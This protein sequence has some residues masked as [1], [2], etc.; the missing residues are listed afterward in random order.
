[1]ALVFLTGCKKEAEDKLRNAFHSGT[2]RYKMTVTVETPEGEKTGSAVRE[3][4]VKQNPKILPEVL[5]HMKVT[6]EAV[7]VDLGERGKLFAL[8]RNHRG[9]DYAHMVVYK[10][11]GG[12]LSP[13]GI[14]YLQQSVG[15]RA[16][17]TPTDYPMLVMFKDI[18]DPKTVTPVLTWAPDENPDRRGQYLI[19]ENRFEEL[20]GKGVKLKDITIEVTDEPVT[21]GVREIRPP[22]GPETGYMEWFKTL[23][24]GDAR[25]IGPYDFYKGRK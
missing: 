13:D 12:N 19:K 4:L 5:P 21:W 22:Y 24:Y 20:F 11:I 3:V 9:P 18:N 8:L 16:T 2:Y 6:G 23:P 17:L 10:T 25:K 15:K 1:M 7:V 14:E